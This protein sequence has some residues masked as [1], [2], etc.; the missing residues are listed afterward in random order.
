MPDIP[1]IEDITPEEAQELIDNMLPDLRNFFPFCIPFDVLAIAQ[2]FSSDNR[3][4]PVFDWDLPLGVYGE[5]HIHLDLSQWD[6]IA[7]LLRSLELALF[8]LG[9]MQ[10]A[11]AVD[12]K[13]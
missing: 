8:I 5:Q 3:E 10:F 1:S 12:T 4:A 6:D 9:L 13:D 2:A 7:A 11:R